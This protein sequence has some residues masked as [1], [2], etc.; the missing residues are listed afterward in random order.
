MKTLNERFA[1]T[2]EKMK[3]AITMKQQQQ[4]TDD[5]TCFRAVSFKIWRI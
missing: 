4:P 1:D 3:D 2:T 5:H